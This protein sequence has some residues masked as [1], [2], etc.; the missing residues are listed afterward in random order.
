M[1]C[2]N[3]MLSTA[4]SNFFASF[5]A[6]PTFWLGYSGGLDSR[7]LLALC[8]QYHQ[9]TPIQ[10]KVIH[11]NHGLHPA[12]K[13]WAEQCAKDCKKYGF[14]YIEHTIQLKLNAGDSLE[15]V[16]RI[17]RYTAFAN[18]M[19]YGDVLLTAHQQD[20][21]A[22]TLLLQLLRGAGLKGLAAM[23]AKT[24]FGDGF[25]A[26][27][28]LAFPRDVLQNYAKQH[29]LTWIDDPSN[30]DLRL[31]RNFIRQEILSRLKHRWPTASNLIAR[32]A[33]HCAEAQVLL[34]DISVTEWLKVAGSRVNTL[35]VKKLLNLEKAKQCLVLR[36]WFNKLGHPTPD[37]KKLASICQSVLPA[38][39]DRMPSIHW[40]NTELRRYRDDLYLMPSLLPHDDKQIVDWEIMQPLELLGG[41][42]I[43]AVLSK[44]YGLRA[45]VKRVSLRFRSAGDIFHFGKR[46]KQYLK[47]LFQE[48]GVPPWERNRIPLLFVEEQLVMVVGYYIADDFAATGEQMGYTICF[49]NHS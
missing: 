45:E 32:S 40:R 46:G 26:R 21:Q 36:T 19:K 47:N 11:I 20:D 4:I 22:E 3:K 31:T 7:V 39:S 37:M 42:K 27:P 48:W 24:G 1:G 35:S 49:R 15:E 43:S 8:A 28:L 17:G 2:R 5:Q 10:L 29:Q 41:G 14:E 33:S 30:A 23:P 38:K 25:H 34:E 18:Y 6:K 13:T 16:A 12:A 9:A 44:G